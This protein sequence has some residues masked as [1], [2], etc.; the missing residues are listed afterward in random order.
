MANESGFGQQDPS[1][2]VGETNPLLFM[3][4]QQISKI[5]TIKIVQVKAVD[6]DAK[7]VDVQPMVNQL[8]G[9]NRSTPHGTILG[10]PYWAWQFGKNKI[11]ADPVVGDIGIMACAD[12]DISAVKATKA[13]SN[14]GSDN[15]F[16]AADGIY[17]GGVL[18]GDPD[19]EIKF[20][21]TGME[22]H[23]KNSNSLVT[24]STGWAFTGPV[25]FNQTV[26][27]KGVATLEGALQLGG[28]IENVSGG[29]YV[30]DIHVGGTVTGD[31][32]V[33]AGGI[34]GKNH[35]HG[36]VQTGG[37]NTAGPHN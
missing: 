12:R 14:P 4:W 35:K 7:T 29:L 31:T 10:I 6:T 26:D 22:L 32:D 37:G 18:N 23:D 19:Q 1:D 21:D 8:D 30:G 25:V 3:I 34:S 24:S 13:V 17:F 16:A 33:V 28:S 15:R 5:S 2:S 27:V 9:D 36:G 11:S 20:T